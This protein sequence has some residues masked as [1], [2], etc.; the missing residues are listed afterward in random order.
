MK[1][2]EKFNSSF[3]FSSSPN[4]LPLQFFTAILTVSPAPINKSVNN[5]TIMSSEKLCNF[6]FFS[7]P[8]S[9]ISISLLKVEIKLRACDAMTEKDEDFLI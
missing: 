1:L 4:P 8:L 6:I 2:N 7:K 3:H 9:E 5:L